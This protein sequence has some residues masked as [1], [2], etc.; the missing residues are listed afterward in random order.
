V[1]Y[2]LEREG[3]R[4]ARSPKSQPLQYKLV[5]TAVERLEAGAGLAARLIGRS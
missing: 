2:W 5:A 3:E 1:A 4:I